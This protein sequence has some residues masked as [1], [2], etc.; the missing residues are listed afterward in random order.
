MSFQNDCLFH[1]RL[2]CQKQSLGKM[3]KFIIRDAFELPGLL[4]LVLLPEPHKQST[5]KDSAPIYNSLLF[6]DMQYIPL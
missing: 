1:C 6:L 3:M 4:C 2:H 5:G